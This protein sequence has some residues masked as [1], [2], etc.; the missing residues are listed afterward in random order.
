MTASAASG[1][2]SLEYD[3]GL[4][5][6]EQV[7]LLFSGTYILILSHDAPYNK[8]KEYHHH[9]NLRDLFS[10]KFFCKK[11]SQMGVGI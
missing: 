8:H 3:P 2:V 10:E 11:G 5:K 1:D 4:A 7:D 6:Q 9:L